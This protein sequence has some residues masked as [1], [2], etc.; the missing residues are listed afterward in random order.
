MCMAPY[1]TTTMECFALA[2]FF[3]EF[4]FLLEWI[5]DILYPF[6]RIEYFILYRKMLSEKE[7]CLTVALAVP[8][9]MQIFPLLIFHC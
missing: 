9:A 1:I 8:V 5:M 6:F 4:C 3:Y 2:L 7:I